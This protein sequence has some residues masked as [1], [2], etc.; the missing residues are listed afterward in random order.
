MALVICAEIFIFFFF[1]IGKK[2]NS[3]CTEF[4]KYEKVFKCGVRDTFN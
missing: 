1:I 3:V 2:A 4:I